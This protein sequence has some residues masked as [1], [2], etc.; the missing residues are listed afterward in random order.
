[1]ILQVLH[2][3]N[4]QGTNVIRHGTTR[5][6]KQRYRCK[7]T[8]CQGGT[9]LLAYTYAGS[10]RR[11]QTTDRRHGDERQWD[12]RYGSCAACQPHHGHQR[13]EKKGP[14]LQPVHHT[15]LAILSPEQVEVELW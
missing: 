2:C 3:P 14:A 7:E 11:G 13:T 10:L 4:C 9:F 12:S 1:M 6:G 8:L 15:V 5:Q